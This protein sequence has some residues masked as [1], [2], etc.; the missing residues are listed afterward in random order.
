VNY[1]FRLPRFPVVLD[2]GEKLFPAK[3]KAQLERWIGK[4]AIKDERRRDIIDA[5]GEGFAYYPKLQTI[6]PHIGIRKW[7]KLQII[8]LYDSRRP[9]ETPVMRRT[10]LGSRTLEDIVYETVELLQEGRKDK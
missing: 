2:S 3:S 10:S 9:P 1:I 6:T 8:D 4:L 5:N 7:K